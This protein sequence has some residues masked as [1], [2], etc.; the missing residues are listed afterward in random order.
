MVHL[1]EFNI[2][3]AVQLNEFNIADA[4]HLNEFN[5]ADAVQLNE[6]N[7]AEEDFTTAETDKTEFIHNTAFN[8]LLDNRC[9]HINHCI[10]LGFVFLLLEFGNTVAVSIIFITEAFTTCITTDRDN[11]FCTSRLNSG[12]RLLIFLIV[13]FLIVIPV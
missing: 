1:N 8:S 13:Y 7:I 11:H 10:F 6:F 12:A 9:I 2:A 5:I 4:V 3:D